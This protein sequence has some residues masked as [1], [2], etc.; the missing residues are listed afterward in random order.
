MRQ[1]KCD[2]AVN[3]FSYP[4]NKSNILREF[5]VIAAR[6]GK[7]FSELMCE[8]L[9]EYVKNHSQGNNT[10]RLD[11]W[12]EDPTFKVLPTLLAPTEKWNNYVD[13]CSDD[14]CTKIAVMANHVHRLVQMRRTKEWKKRQQ[15]Q[16]H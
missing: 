7:S 6:E 14:E 3:S 4:I 12:T 1:K 11:V 15:I 5:R 8:I 9:E 13:E 16:Q 2:V 10:F